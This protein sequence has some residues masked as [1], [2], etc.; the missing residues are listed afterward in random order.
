MKKFKVKYHN[1]EGTEVETEYQLP[2][3]DMLIIYLKQV[4]IDFDEI[5]VLT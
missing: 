1:K 4:G 3:L 5:Q 2:N